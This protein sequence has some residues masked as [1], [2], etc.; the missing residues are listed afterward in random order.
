MKTSQS[1]LEQTPNPEYWTPACNSW[2][3]VCSTDMHDTLNHV[4]FVLQHLQV[5]GLMILT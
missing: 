1:L 4:L 3:G 5:T 2:S